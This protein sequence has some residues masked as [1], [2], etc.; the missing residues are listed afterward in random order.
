MAIATLTYGIDSDVQEQLFQLMS[1]AVK[2]L[3]QS[4]T[5][6]VGGHTSEG[7]E[8]AFGLSVTGLIDEHQLLRKG[9]M[10]CG[11]VLLL[12]KALGTGTLFAADMLR[13]ARGHWI[14][15][16]IE[17]MLISNQAAGRCLQRHA[18]N[19]CTDVTGFGLLGHLQE[20][21][22]SSAMDVRLT[23]DNIPAL[24]GAL[25]TMQDG[26][27]SSLHPQNSRLQNSLLCQD[28]SR[29]HPHY[30][31][32]FDPQTAGGLLASIPS[33]QAGKCIN[34]LIELGYEQTCIIGEVRE[35]SSQLHR[36]QLI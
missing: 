22:K 16:A 10:Q 3:N 31:L 7:A 29:L 17:S 28:S 27:F 33:A 11:D 18:A 8:L 14:D 25:K 36:I 6:L 9:G 21:M 19:A 26:Y 12:C 35:Q 23:L 15:K 30:P 34:E 1:G 4:N 5:S 24:E 20:M 2:V 13:H 32:L